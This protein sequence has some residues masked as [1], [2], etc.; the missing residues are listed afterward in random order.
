MIANVVEDFRYVDLDH[1]VAFVEEL[2]E[3]VLV[4]ARVEYEQHGRL[5]CPYGNRAQQFIVFRIAELEF[6]VFFL[7][8]N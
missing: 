8:F 1:F 6:S 2:D 7:L 3:R 4:R 5:E